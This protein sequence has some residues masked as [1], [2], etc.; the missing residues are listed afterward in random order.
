M[1]RK[2]VLVVGIAVLAFAIGVYTLYTAWS[3]REPIL[4]GILHSRSGSLAA[5]EQPLI[6]AELMAIAEINAAGGLLGRSVKP[7]VRDG[8]SSPSVFAEE[9]RRLITEDKVSVIMGGYTSPSRK[10]I[11]PVVE[12]YKHLLIFP[13]S[14]EGFELSSHIVYAGGPAN[15]QVTPAVSWCRENLKAKRFF[16]VGTDSLYSRAAQALVRDDV[17][18]LGANVAGDEYVPPDSRDVGE[19]VE[20]LQKAAPDVV[21]STLEGASNL[22]FYERLQRAG[23]KPE[24]MPVVSFTVSEED[25]RTLPP[26]VMTGHYAA[27]NY[28]QSIARSENE[29]F[30]RRFRARYGE[31]RVTFDTLSSAYNGVWFWAQ[32]VTEAE[33]AEVSAVRQTIRRQSLDAAEGIIAIDYENL[34]AWRAFALGKIR[35]DGQFEI[36]YSL[37]KPIPPVPYPRTRTRAEWDGFLVDLNR[38]WGGQWSPAA[39]ASVRGATP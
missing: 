23:V 30:V 22:V 12:E 9:A 8:R 13:T 16:L 4:V 29:E 15:Q 10:A 7:I 19:L 24:R 36:V 1:N 18:A 32:A 31:E 37:P 20:K 27:W 38:R 11:K 34:N 21:I 2:V 6:D 25:L 35:P 33:S 28:M 17:K 26:Q 3:R 14:Y 5:S 39:G